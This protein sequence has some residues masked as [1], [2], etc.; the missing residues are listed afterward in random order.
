MDIVYFLKFYIIFTPKILKKKTDK[1]FLNTMR[2]IVFLIF[3]LFLCLA[4]P[5]ALEGKK[6]L[7]IRSWPFYFKSYLMYLRD[8]I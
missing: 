3:S 4:S 8:E 2:A 5:S 7:V 6:S 1:E